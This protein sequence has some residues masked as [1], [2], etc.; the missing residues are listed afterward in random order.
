VKLQSSSATVATDNTTTYTIYK[1]PKALTFAVVNAGLASA[2]DAGGS[3][4]EILVDSTQKQ[5]ISGFATANRRTQ[6]KDKSFTEA[7][8]ILESD[9]GTISVKYA[10]QAPVSSVTILD[11]SK[12]R[13]A[14]LRNVKPVPL[15]KQG[16]SERVMIEAEFTIEALGENSSS[17]IYGAL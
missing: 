9:F 11:S 8:D 14:N 12:W 7:V 3:P 5:A 6:G 17:V 13:L 15:A 16:S 4:D 1:A 10:N 2:F